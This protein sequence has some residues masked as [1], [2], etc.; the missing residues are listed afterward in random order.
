MS[1]SERDEWVDAVNTREVEDLLTEH[2]V[3]SPP[4]LRPDRREFFVG[5]AKIGL[6]VPMAAGLLAACGSGTTTSASG[7]AAGAAFKRLTTL[8]LNVSDNYQS[9]AG[10]KAAYVTADFTNPFGYVQD[11]FFSSHAAAVGW[12]YKAFNGALN[13]QAMSSITDNLISQGYSVIWLD[14]LDAAAQSVD[15]AKAKAAGVVWIN[16][17]NDTL[18]YPTFGSMV[19][20]YNAGQLAAKYILQKKPNGK[21]I[22]I[23][24][25]STSTAGQGRLKGSVD[26]FTAGGATILT[27]SSAGGWSTKTSHDLFAGMLQR[28]PQIDGVWAGNDDQARGVSQAAS[29][30]GR[31]GQMV[32]VGCDALKTGQ[33]AI[34]SGLVDASVGQNQ[35]IQCQTAAGVAE[36]LLRAGLSGNGVFGMYNAPIYII[37]KS[38]VDTVWQSPR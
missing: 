5:A 19:S 14:P 8:K 10:K 12:D 36:G 4:R 18:E 2:A 26:A 32:I 15:V 23:V 38:N 33:D 20:M 9:I 6:G 3:E 24:G 30:A 21:V 35:E 25:E 29:E 17:N 13:P 31:R 16:T 11:S 7:G 28:F 27:A 37:D 34:R 22:S 1:R